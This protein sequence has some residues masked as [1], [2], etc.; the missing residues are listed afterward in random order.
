MSDRWM[1]GPDDSYFIP[2]WWAFSPEYP[3]NE[4]E[5]GW[6]AAVWLE[7]AIADG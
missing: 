6:R 7:E 2:D 4:L 1:F 3:L 5:L